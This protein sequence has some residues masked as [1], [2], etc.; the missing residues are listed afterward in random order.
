MRTSEFIATD[1]PDFEG[2]VI[3]SVE[4]S[5]GVFRIRRIPKS[6]LQMTGPPGPQGPVG[7]GSGD[8][9]KSVYD[10]TSVNERLIGESEYGTDIAA[11][12]ASLSGKQNSDATLTALAS[13]DSNGILVQTATNTFIGRTIVG[14]ADQITVND[15]SGV[16]ANPTISLATNAK[17]VQFGITI[18]GG[19]AVIT[20]GVKGYLR[21]PV[22]MT[23]TGW[24]ITADQSG[25]TVID[26]WKDT[27]ANYPPTVADAIFTTKPTLSS[28]IKNQNLAPTFVGA[29]ATVAAGDYIAFNV[30]S[31]TTVQIVQLSIIGSLV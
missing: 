25:S 29:G 18:D 16:S 3:G 8:M 2:F 5:P 21:V 12:N 30:D 26:V 23:I 10:P 13:Y 20:T 28:V 31:A 19:G 24:E 9:L 14:T 1:D 6:F 17:R 22:A 11:I 27:Y 7:P 15:G 4:I